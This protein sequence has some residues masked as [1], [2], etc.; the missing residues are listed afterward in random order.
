MS[1]YHVCFA[2]PDLESAMSEFTA[3]AGVRWQQPA[4]EKLDQWSYRIAFT[5]D[6]PPFIELIEAAPGGPWGDTSQPRFHHIGYWTSDIV[7]GSARLV[8]RGVP[9]AFTG[10]PYGRP[11]AYHYMASVGAHIELVDAARQSSFLRTWQPGGEAM[12]AIQEESTGDDL[13][14]S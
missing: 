10:C 5:A 6:G 11:F 3:A 2:V 9:Q 12:A 14:Q 7:A 8:D 13:G 4:N 1:F